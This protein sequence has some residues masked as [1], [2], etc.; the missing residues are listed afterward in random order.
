MINYIVIV[1]GLSLSFIFGA[2][3]VYY[4]LVR[5]SDFFLIEFKHSY[6]QFEKKLTISS[7]NFNNQLDT[8]NSN[9]VNNINL[10]MQ[11]AVNIDNKIVKI[12]KNL[13]DFNQILENK[14]ELENEIVKL[15]NIIKRLEKKS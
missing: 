4:F 9:F 3:L 10:I 2:L 8:A 6:S 11:N 5:T 12:H 14:K 1:V 13:N 7:D 15:K